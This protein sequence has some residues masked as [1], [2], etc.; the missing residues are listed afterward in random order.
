MSPIGR[1]IDLAI[2]VLSA[3]G[4][5]ISASLLVAEFLA[6]SGLEID[7]VAELKVFNLALAFV[8]GLLFSVHYGRLT[9]DRSEKQI[10][11]VRYAGCPKWMQM[12]CVIIVSCG[13]IA[14]FLPLLL[15]I[16]GRVGVDD[17]SQLPS[18]LS[19][20]FGLMV[21]GALPAQIYSVRHLTPH[22]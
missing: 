3:I 18:T 12:S 13:V 4:L 20:G 16:F 6:F 10:E 22:G 17:G 11:S 15:K 1:A 19:A 5:L 8:T 7:A 21:H 2:Y 14:F 9:S